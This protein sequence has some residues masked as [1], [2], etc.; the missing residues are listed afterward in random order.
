MVDF[1]P[2]ARLLPDQSAE[3]LRIEGNA[4]HVHHL[5]ELGL[6]Q[7][8]RI[9][10]FRPGNPCILRA[11]GNKICLRTGRFLHVFVKPDDEPR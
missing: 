5:R 11:A 2:L 10:M 7:G 9:Q 4:E 1:V 3:I 6:R 8:C